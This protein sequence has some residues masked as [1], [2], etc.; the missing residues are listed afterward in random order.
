MRNPVL[1]PF[2]GR[3][4]DLCSHPSCLRGGRATK[5]F[6]NTSG[7]VKEPYFLIQELR[8]ST[9]KHTRKPSEEQ[10]QQPPALSVT[11]MS[12][13]WAGAGIKVNSYKK[14]RIFIGIT[15]APPDWRGL[16]LCRPKAVQPHAFV[17]DS[18]TDSRDYT[19][20]PFPRRASPR[21]RKARGTPTE[22]PPGPARC[23]PTPAPPG[24]A[25]PGA[26]PLSP[27]EEQPHSEDAERQRESGEDMSGPRV[28]QPAARRAR[29]AGQV[30][31]RYVV[32]EPEPFVPEP[33]PQRR[34]RGRRHLPPAAAA[35][36]LRRPPQTRGG[37]A[38]HPPAPPLTPQR[39]G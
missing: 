5:V 35:A 37:V 33:G 23:S 14:H 7:R 29:L 9:I 24:P 13:S 11:P 6:N 27:L 1:H 20:S 25:A 31:P 22:P 32:R 17:H 38:E 3:D 39:I 19:M 12:F 2:M 36:A 28:L 18:P 8:E 26:A 4:E 21:P 15:S 16:S 10:Q 30:R 34:G